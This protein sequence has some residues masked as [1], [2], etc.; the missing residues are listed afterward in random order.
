MIWQIVALAGEGFGGV[1][2]GLQS[3][4]LGNLKSSFKDAGYNIPDFDVAWFQGGGGYGK[5]NRLLIGGWGAGGSASF[6]SSYAKA[7]VS[8]GGGGFEMGY[9]VIELPF[10][11]CYP[12]LGFGGWGT[13]IK[14]TPLS[15]TI[16]QATLEDALKNPQEVASYN[17][18]VEISCSAFMISIG[19]MLDFPIRVGSDKEFFEIIP[20]IKANAIITPQG[21]WSCAQ[22]NLTNLPQPSAVNFTIT[23]GIS[24]GG[25]GTEE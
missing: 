6:E 13:T 25:G 23:A 5:I 15:K 2:F 19:A 9:A 18:K 16:E 4:V 10:L 17:D 8:V 11:R 14:I 20:F 24:F 1:C 7:E 12:L 21:G 3:S 22:A